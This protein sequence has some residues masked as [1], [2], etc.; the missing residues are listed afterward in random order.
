VRLL[1]NEDP[2]TGRHGWRPGKSINHRLKHA[3]SEGRIEE[4]DIE[5]LPVL[6]KPLHGVAVDKFDPVT[7]SH[8][9]P[10]LFEHGE[11][12]SGLLDQHDPS[13]T[14]RRRLET[15]YSGAREEIE[16]ACSG[17]VELEPVEEGLAY[18]VSGRPQA[19]SIGKL[20]N[21]A[22]TLPADDPDTVATGLS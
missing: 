5:S 11:N 1:L 12:A 4:D 3:L 14:T 18:A 9:S 10:V 6:R 7:E 21:P 17:N 8:L 16:T 13:G 19:W 22:A 20:Q 15:Q 2:G